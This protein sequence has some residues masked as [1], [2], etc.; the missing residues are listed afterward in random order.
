VKPAEPNGHKLERFLFDALPAARSVAL[1]EVARDDEYAPV[2]NAE[3]NDS[4]QTAREALDAVARRW[5]DAGGIEVP[6]DQWVEVDHSRIDGEEDV[7]AG[8]RRAQDAGL[9]LAARTK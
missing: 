2:K 5:L 3:G 7:R 4:P 8:V 1:V 6:A 9:V